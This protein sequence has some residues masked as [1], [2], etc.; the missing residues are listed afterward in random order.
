MDTIDIQLR[1]LGDMIAY[2]AVIMFVFQN[3]FSISLTNVGFLNV[4]SITASFVVDNVVVVGDITIL[5]LVV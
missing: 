4:G 1:Q 3:T 2:R 5:L